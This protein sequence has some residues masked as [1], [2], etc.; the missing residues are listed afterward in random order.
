MRPGDRK[1]VVP[2]DFSCSCGRHVRVADDKAGSKGKCPNCGQ[3]V[4]IPAANPSTHAAPRTMA[5]PAAPVSA[6]PQPQAVP[7]QLSAAGRQP[8]T[9][10]QPVIHGPRRIVGGHAYPVPAG[11]TPSSAIAPAPQLSGISSAEPPADGDAAS[12]F[13]EPAEAA[14][15]PMAQAAAAYAAQHAGDSPLASHLPRAKRRRNLH[16]NFGFNLLGVGLLTGF[17]LPV[18]T[19]DGGATTHTT[20]ANMELIGDSK[21]PTALRLFAVTPLLASLAVFIVGNAMRGVARGVIV[22][23]IGI[24]SY[25]VLFL[26]KEVRGGFDYFSS[27]SASAGLMTAMLLLCGLTLMLAGI[28]S[29]RHQP[30]YRP[31]SIIA[32]VGSAMFLVC[33]FIPQGSADSMPIA[34]VFNS[35]DKHQSADPEIDNSPR[36]CTAAAMLVMMVAAGYTIFL[37]ASKRFSRKQGNIALVI[38][39]ASFA[40]AYT[41]LSLTLNQIFKFFLIGSDARIF[42]AAAIVTAKLCFWFG[43]L[44]TLIPVGFSELMLGIAEKQAPDGATGFEVQMI[45]GPTMQPQPV[46]AMPQNFPAAPQPVF[47]PPMHR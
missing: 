37:A 7:P 36:Y 30:Q 46:H 22:A 35:G 12:G 33:L 27:S 43:T 1:G 2:I 38:V 6:S 45:S 11:Y 31:L 40:L 18:F 41:A 15:D 14:N 4:Q 19:S 32:I 34:A 20:F 10:P 44:A 24:A 23:A 39:F 42:I 29:L 16:S 8:I 25:A 17:M 13:E 3:V 26:D 21:T 28:L 9:Q 47:P 5:V